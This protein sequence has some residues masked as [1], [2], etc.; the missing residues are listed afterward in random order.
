M[1]NL[2]PFITQKAEVGRSL[3]VPRSVE[4]AVNQRN[5]KKQESSRFG[6]VKSSKYHFG[7]QFI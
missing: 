6:F 1:I 2:D 5:K 4:S 3:S 7:S